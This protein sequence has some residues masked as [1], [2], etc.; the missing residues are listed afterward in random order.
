MV[1]TSSTFNKLLQECAISG[2]P[3]KA[4]S[5]LEQMRVE[6]VALSGET[7]ELLIRAWI[8]SNNIDPLIV[9]SEV[10]ILLDSVLDSGI[11]IQGGLLTDI[12]TF[13]GEMK[14]PIMA[15][16]ISF[17]LLSSEIGAV[18]HVNLALQAWGLSDSEEAARRSESLVAMFVERGHSLNEESYELLLDL[19]IASA[20]SEK[21]TK[22]YEVLLRMTADDCKPTQQ[23]YEKLIILL[24]EEGKFPGPSKLVTDVLSSMEIYDINLSQQCYAQC[25]LQWARSKRNESPRAISKLLSTMRGLGYKTSDIIPLHC[26]V[27]SSSGVADAVL[28]ATESLLE[29]RADGSPLFS[30]LQ[31]VVASKWALSGF[32]D[33]AELIIMMNMQ[34]SSLETQSSDFMSEV[35][36]FVLEDPQSRQPAI[37]YWNSIISAYGR[38]D[39]V[40]AERA[41]V[42]LLNAY[43]YLY[44]YS[45]GGD[46]DTLA[47]KNL[48]RAE[49]L[50]ID[51]LNT[52]MTTANE[53]HDSSSRSGASSVHPVTSE[54]GEFSILI[55]SSLDRSRTSGATKAENLYKRLRLLDVEP[56]MWTY[57]SLI[58][59]WS[60]LDHPQQA[61][62]I[63]NQLDTETDRRPSSLYEY[64]MLRSAL[65]QGW[66]KYRRNHSIGSTI[67]IHDIDQRISSLFLSICQRAPVDAGIDRNIKNGDAIAI[68]RETYDELTKVPL[69]LSYDAHKAFLLVLSTSEET[70][71]DD[72]SGYFESIRQLRSLRRSGQSSSS[73]TVGGSS[74]PGPVQRQSFEIIQRELNADVAVQ[75]FQRMFRQGLS[76]DIQCY[77][78]LFRVFENSSP[79]VYWIPDK[80]LDIVRN[81]KEIGTEPS[82]SIYVQLLRLWTRS[83][84]ADSARMSEGVFRIM[85]RS[86]LPD[87]PPSVAF[88]LLLGSW[89]CS[90]LP[91]AMNKAM[92]VVDTMKAAN[93]EF[94]A[95]T[96]TMLSQ[97]LYDSFKRF[98]DQNA[99]FVTD[100]EKS[101][102]LV[103]G[104]K[105]VEQQ[106]STFLSCFQSG[107]L[108]STQMTSNLIASWSLIG[109][110]E[111]LHKARWLLLIWTVIGDSTDS[112][113]QFIRKTQEAYNKLL[114]STVDSDMSTQVIEIAKVLDTTSTSPFHIPQSVLTM[115]VKA[116]DRLSLSQL[117]IVLVD[118]FKLCGRA[119]LTHKQV[120]KIST[121]YFTRTK[122][123]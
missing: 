73:A 91:N 38:T 55:D 87:K 19:W 102:Y 35:Q 100:E 4:E 61:E 46:N 72:S 41:K 63:L 80:A 48:T 99:V 32:P 53:D 9:A 92:E 12:L 65:I 47:I 93:I 118:S 106:E 110:V 74:F 69:V 51:L 5:I 120:I 25:A 21:C 108:P 3:V 30:V 27:W 22:A 76:P 54:S 122:G 29:L 15:E 17:K 114:V 6:E 60:Q 116:W 109:T 18:E 104:M 81:M 26:L 103:A 31:P 77:E 11:A 113:K 98:I 96:F 39:Y 42:S 97:G 7:Y 23:T 59:M 10:D 45:Y 49:Q 57:Y 111:T 89:T 107:L 13:F 123:F 8:N 34:S 121:Y 58:V 82:A 83:E 56:D 33:L 84:R 66:L 112:N 70:V 67:D 75:V 94:S 44:N 79:S 105:L 64:T 86:L 90:L 1:P 85:L 14:L 117:Q 101:N 28:R 24:A 36:H 52:Y 88:D 2:D 119:N 95:D 68:I 43:Q 71:T 16:K 115:L 40:L 37:Q 78:L 62:A 20:D 50:M